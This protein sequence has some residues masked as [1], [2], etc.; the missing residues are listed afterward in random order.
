[1]IHKSILSPDLQRALNQGYSEQEL[2]L[3]IEARIP[4]DLAEKLDNLSGPEL[5]ALIRSDES[6][7]SSGAVKN[8]VTY[9]V[10]NEYQEKISFLH[11]DRELGTTTINLRMTIKDLSK[12]VKD[13]YPEIDSIR[14]ARM[15][16]SF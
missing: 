10:Q 1:M 13:Q 14:L 6:P 8:L 5:G 3:V 16:R 12:I 2:S 11:Y 15:H 4:G 7:I 9:L